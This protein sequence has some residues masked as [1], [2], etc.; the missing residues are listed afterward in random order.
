MRCSIIIA[1]SLIVIAIIISRHPSGFTDM[2]NLKDKRCYV[3]DK[4]LGTPFTF[5]SGFNGLVYSYDECNKLKGTYKYDS[6][7]PNGKGRCYIHEKN[8]VDDDS[9]N[10]VCVNKPGP[11]IFKDDPRCYVNNIKLGYDKSDKNN[12]IRLYNKKECD[13]LNGI[14]DK[15]TNICAIKGGNPNRQTINDAFSYLC[16]T[17][18]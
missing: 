13:M 14:Y 10:I 17:R 4:L 3:D 11:V 5:G 1:I 18:L 12:I 9:Y 16:G 8:M 6:S 15:S 2:P 7:Y